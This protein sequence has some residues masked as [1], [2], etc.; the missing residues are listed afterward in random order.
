MKTDIGKIGVNI[1]GLTDREVMDLM[2]EEFGDAGLARYFHYS[3]WNTENQASVNIMDEPGLH[4]RDR[5]R[6]FVE[7][8]LEGGK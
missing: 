8:M 4:R 6:E 7:L 2:W 3:L 5:V 1:G